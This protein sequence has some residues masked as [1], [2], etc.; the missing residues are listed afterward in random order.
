MEKHDLIRLRTKI[1]AMLAGL[2]TT[3]IAARTMLR[4][5]SEAIPNF[6]Q[7]ESDAAKGEHDLQH[8]LKINGY[9]TAQQKLLQAALA[10]MDNGSYGVCQE[11][12]EEIGIRRLEAIPGATWC[13]QCQHLQEH[14]FLREPKPNKITNHVQI[15]WAA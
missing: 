9:T 13:I 15:R 11:C 4:E 1:I 8:T 5:S 12:G 7:D 2:E 6:L 10:R 3:A 14:G